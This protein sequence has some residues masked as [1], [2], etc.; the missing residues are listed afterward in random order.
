MRKKTC[1]LL[2]KGC[3]GCPSL[4]NVPWKHLYPYISNVKLVFKCSALS[5][6]SCH[7]FFWASP[8]A[9]S[10]VFL[11]TLLIYVGAG[12]G[13]ILCNNRKIAACSWKRGYE[14]S[15]AEEKQSSSGPQNQNNELKDAKTHCKIERN[16]IIHR[17]FVTLTHFT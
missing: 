14:S 8:T 17:R 10:F 15:K 13:S 16:T 2:R 3:P 5:S 4:F 6:L 7:T 1:I 11:F 9:E 12:H